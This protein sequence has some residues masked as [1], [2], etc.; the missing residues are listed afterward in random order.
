M[1]VADEVKKAVDEIEKKVK[2]FCKLK[3]YK[4]GTIEI[5]FCVDSLNIEYRPPKEKIN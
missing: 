3:G 2:Y 5:N 4:K 1:I